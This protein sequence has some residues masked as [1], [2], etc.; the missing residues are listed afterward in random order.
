[1]SVSREP[2]HEE[3]LQHRRLL[4]AFPMA[5]YATDAAETIT[6]FNQAAAAFIGDRPDLHRDHWWLSWRLFTWTG[7]FCR[8]QDSRRQ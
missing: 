3:E 7:R 1:M 4:E 6:Y 2:P 5:I 8:A